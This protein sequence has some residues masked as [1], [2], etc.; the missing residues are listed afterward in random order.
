MQ[1]NILQS[2]FLLNP[3]ITYLNFG[4]HS[5]TKPVEHEEYKISTGTQKTGEPVQFIVF[6]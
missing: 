6:K 1:N 2:Q 5:A 4:S 3:D